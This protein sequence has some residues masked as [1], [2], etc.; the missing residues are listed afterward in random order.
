MKKIHFVILF[1]LF[2]SACSI[3][4]NTST[5][6]S[7]GGDGGVFISSDRGETWQQKV[8]VRQ[9]QQ[10]IV[11]I[12]NTNIGYFYFHPMNPDTI[13]VSTLENG[14]WKSENNGDTWTATNFNAGYVTGF[15]IDPKNND[16]LYVGFQNTVQKSTDAGKTWSVVYTNQPGNTINQ[17]RVDPFDNRNI[18]A[19]T[20]G[21]VLL[22]SEDQAVTW[23][24]LKQFPGKDLRKLVVLKNDSRI[25][26]LVTQDGILKSTDGGVSW[27]DNMT[28]ALTKVSAL[29]IN[30]FVF[31]DRNPSIMYV[32]SN[33]GI[34]RSTDGGTS[35]QIVPTVIPAS[36]VAIQSVA[37]NTYDEKEIFFA[38]GSTFYKSQDNGETW[39]TLKN[40]PSARLFKVLAAHPKKPGTL[41]LGVLQVK[42]K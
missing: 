4:L 8:F 3:K 27:V 30:D 31:A 17:V 12:G 29:P 21:G 18:L 25:M 42:K 1:I 13:F 37:I 34:A 15:D 35:W 26:F 28:K 41:F 16:T 39:Q 40:I 10:K 33:I 14:L 20:N 2:F 9:E 19:A 6:S 38:A 7:S 5:S 23:R 36:T 11:S 24:I 32:A 22:K